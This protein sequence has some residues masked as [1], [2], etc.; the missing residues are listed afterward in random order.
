MIT[1]LFCYLRVIRRI[2]IL[3]TVLYPMAIESVT[4]SAKNYQANPV[5]IGDSLIGPG[6]QTY[7]IA[8]IGINHNGSLGTT[9]DL[10]DV[11]ADAGCQA[12]KFQKR[13]LSI[14]Y[15]P[16]AMAK[17]RSVPAGVMAAAI[18]RGAFDEKRSEYLRGLI[19]DAGDADAPIEV[20]TGDQK[21]MLEFG[22]SD[23]REISRYCAEKGIDWFASPWDEPSVDFLEEHGPVA[24]KIAS[25]GLTD[26][27][28]L[29]KVRATGKPIIL[30]T[31][32]SDLE[33]VATAVDELGTE[34]LVL[35]Q[36]TS[37]YPSK[38]HELDINGIGTLAERF[39]VPVGYSGHE[40]DILPS[41]LAVSQGAVAV[42]R[43]ITLDQGMYGSDQKASVPPKDLKRMVEDIRRVPII[44][45]SDEIRVQESEV[46]VAEALRRVKDF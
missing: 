24:Y 32:M 18:E 21:R 41:V 23:F 11:A 44:L 33:Q 43:H 28:L 7:V 1:V 46:K 22:Y 31:G 8:E 45:G 27:G 36:C 17:P 34:G 12:V 20:L 29:R 5:K 9:K 26:R 15:T 16:E 42:E 3:G 6:Q 10:I 13:D 2:Y 30:S 25:A 14:T 40:P 38:D 39:R 4:S 37:T 19:R 35:L